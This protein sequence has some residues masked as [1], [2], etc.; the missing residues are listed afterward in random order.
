MRSIFL[1]IL[2][3]GIV[4]SC[5]SKEEKLGVEASYIKAYEL[6]KDKSY[7][8]SAKEFEKLDDDF[9][10]SRWAIKGQTM[11]LYS[12]H[13]SDEPEKVIQVAED[14]LRLHPSS[15]FAPYMIYM[16]G[17]TYYNRIPP[18]DRAQ[19]ETQKASYAFRELIARFPDDEHTLDALKKLNFVDEHLAGSKMAIG[20]YQIKTKNFIGAIKNFDEVCLRYRLSKQV[21]EAYF[22][23]FEIY[24]K[25]GIETEA[26]KAKE[27]LL[28][29]FP[30]SYWAKIIN[31]KE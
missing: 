9:P 30:S 3:F 10:F 31:E 14:F 1:L 21:P 17:L 18:I 29:R 22:R 24:Q 19:D 15:E 27:H 23:L 4:F 8:E 16:K 2:A 7:S 6:L 11:A 13:K 12:Y 25:I 28:S 26:N 5:K 20:R